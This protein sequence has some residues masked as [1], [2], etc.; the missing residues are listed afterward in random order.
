VLTVSA[1]GVFGATEF[2]RGGAAAPCCDLS[3]RPGR[4]PAIPPAK[5]AGVIGYGAA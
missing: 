1:D 5:G 4:T 3:L 2:I